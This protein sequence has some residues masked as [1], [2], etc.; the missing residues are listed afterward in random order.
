MGN[1]VRRRRWRLVGLLAVVA[2]GVVLWIVQPR[3]RQPA[4]AGR[5]VSY[6]FKRHLRAARRNP[7]NTLSVRY[8]QPYKA[9]DESFYV[10][11]KMGT[12]AVPYLLK[13][14]F[15]YQPDQPLRRGLYGLWDHFPGWMPRPHLSTSA[16]VRPV[17]EAVLCAGNP[18]ADLVLPQLLRHLGGTNGDA[19]VRAVR[20]LGSVGT[21]AERVVPQ[22]VRLWD[23]PELGFEAA[24]SLVRC[25]ARTK[26][27]I[28]AVAEWLKA[29]DGFAFYG[30]WT[31]ENIGA[32]AKPELAAYAS[33]A[34]GKTTNPTTRCALLETLAGADA[35]Q[36]RSFWPM[37]EQ[38][39][40]TE[41]N[42][43]I[44]CRLARVLYKLHEN[45][46]EAVDSLI[47]A[48]AREPNPDRRK[49]MEWELTLV[50]GDYPEE[51]DRLRAIFK[52]ASLR[53]A[54]LIQWLE[55]GKDAGPSAQGPTLAQWH[56]LA[57]GPEPQYENRTMRQ[58]LE[59][60]VDSIEARNAAWNAARQAV[61][62]IGTNGLAWLVTWAESSTTN[63]LYVTRGFTILGAAA[64]PALPALIEL[65][66]TNSTALRGQ[67]YKCL[68]CL[69]L[70][71][72]ALW[73]ALVPVLH[74]PDPDIRLGAAEFLCQ[75]FLA[76]ARK[77]GVS[78]LLPRQT[79]DQI[80]RV[81]GAGP[82][83]AGPQNG[84]Q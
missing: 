67:A 34:L 42:F 12:N 48:C 53:M 80:D 61:K 39:F 4:Y 71:W 46:T 77:A 44:R 38:A 65:V 2:A 59:F 29:Q 5:P 41:T 60:P 66:Q 14:T 63:K 56:V 10:L 3:D 50:F 26:L 76:Q 9:T 32:V 11:L 47:E 55:L 69:Q 83:P 54:P 72:E 68:D 82:R 35:Q 25:S 37:L 28:P 22:L 78:E 21:G 84:S 49:Q 74:H 13:Q 58:W 18:P 43:T 1:V 52:A 64:R 75:R 20:I 17:A 45:R 57:R 24:K 79:R 15:N 27:V 40:N 16:E 7:A 30:V 6:W 36:A 33:S 73:P 8:G 51:Q 23:N 19:R 31:L 81:S 70:D 62:A